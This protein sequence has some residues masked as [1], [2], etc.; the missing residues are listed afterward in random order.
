MSI[1]NMLTS[2]SA[3]VAF[4][5]VVVLAVL[6]FNTDVFYK[7]V[8][9]TITGK[10]PVIEMGRTNIFCQ[11]DN[12]ND[13]CQLTVGSEERAVTREIKF[14]KT[15]RKVPVVF[16]NNSYFDMWNQSTDGSDKA[17]RAELVA[18]DVTTKGFTVKLRTW[19]LSAIW[20]AAVNWVAVENV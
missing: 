2:L 13:V 18:T 10:I 19:G 20:G 1:L 12:P 11:R 14:E 4:V 3:F 6:L 5:L 17:I 15:F 7:K 9:S 8:I 16:L